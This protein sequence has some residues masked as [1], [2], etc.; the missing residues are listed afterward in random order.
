MLQMTMLLGQP[1]Q[2]WKILWIWGT[3]STTGNWASTQDD[4]L[5]Q[6]E[7]APAVVFRERSETIITSHSWLLCLEIS[8][9]P[10]K[11]FLEQLSNATKSLAYESRDY[12][13]IMATLAE[14]Y[15]GS[16]PKTGMFNESALIKKEIAFL[17]SNV[18]TLKHRYQRLAE[19]YLNIEADGKISVPK[20]VSIEVNITPSSTSNRQKRFLPMVLSVLSGALSVS[21]MVEVAQ[22]REEVKELS[23]RTNELLESSQQ[24]WLALQG[25]M[26]AVQQNAEH[27]KTLQDHVNSVV[28]HVEYL[29]SKIDKRVKDEHLHRKMTS[30]L[31]SA[32]NFLQMAVQT[33]ADNLQTFQTDLHNTLFGKLPVSL[34]PREELKKAVKHINTQLPT[35]QQLAVDT[36]SIQ[37]YIQPVFLVGGKTSVYAALELPVANIIRD[38]FKIYDIISH[39]YR[40]GHDQMVAVQLPS[41]ALAVNTAMGTY[42][43]LNS[44]EA[45]ACGFANSKVCMLN[46][47][48]L[49]L[50]TARNC[51]VGWFT[52]NKQMILE[53]CQEKI[54]NPP[55]EIYADSIGKNV[56]LV[57]SQL[58]ITLTQDCHDDITEIPNDINVPPGN[59]I[60]RV[61]E[62]CRA[63]SNKIT[64][65]SQR[66]LKTEIHTDTFL[67][68]QQLQWRSMGYLNM[69]Q[70]SEQ[71]E[72]I[73]LPR[74]KSAAPSGIDPALW[75]TVKFWGNKMNHLKPLVSQTSWLKI[76]LYVIIA[77]L[78]VIIL[79]S[80][81]AAC[82]ACKKYSWIKSFTPP[83]DGHNNQPQHIEMKVLPTLKNLT[84]QL[85]S[86]AK[87]PH[88]SAPPADSHVVTYKPAIQAPTG[89]STTA[90]TESATRNPYPGWTRGEG[91]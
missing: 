90:N 10:H 46:K 24:S 91:E 35:N 78:G 71:S 9:L 89:A 60:V 69:S 8:F 47:P 85:A 74:L 67:E 43:L 25:T 53:T 61:T 37:P 44:A 88:P 13:K 45:L 33:A 36:S 63:I 68:Y 39:P 40:N 65:P 58:S 49:D 51:E 22:I 62:G 42:Q 34:L 18:E 1:L 19:I 31:S 82:I 76:A 55:N 26:Q 4:P 12:F 73:L 6:V 77:V 57:S 32:L 87:S 64:L 75:R 66:Q 30:H 7:A 23:A 16:S 86:A 20:I 17:Y 56:Y 41:M 81:I 15:K 54:I 38:Q 70:L 59:H 14:I 28:E 80:L 21:S 72:E 3:L 50:H 79:G 48:I 84:T 2:L 83:Q 11:T 27:I 29:I 52:K 5:P